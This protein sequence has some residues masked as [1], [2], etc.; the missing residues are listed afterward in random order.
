NPADAKG[1]LLTA[2][3]DVDPVLFLEPKRI[4][5]ALTGEVPD[6]DYR[7]PFGEAKVVREGSTL[8]AFAYGAMIPPTLEAAE[9]VRGDGIDVEVVDLRSLVPLDER[10]VLQSVEKTGR[11]VIVHEAPRFC[12]Y[13]A[14][15]AAILAEK[16]LYSL[17]APVLRVTGYDTPFPY[18]LEHLYLPNVDRIAHALKETARA[19]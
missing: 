18:A 6:G 2:I 8:S 12:G 11:A 9:R 17:K 19:G 10:R 13:G 3:H 15:L 14:E 16:A 4:Y 1:L 5:R 7:V